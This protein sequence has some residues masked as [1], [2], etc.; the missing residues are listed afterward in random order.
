MYIL[1]IH[2]RNRVNYLSLYVQ[3]CFNIRR[4]L[5]VFMATQRAGG[6]VCPK[7]KSKS[8]IRGNAAGHH[9]PE[10]LNDDYG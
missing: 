5:N 8:K 2:E 10:S 7:Q 3:V 1:Y 9:N 4:A 6:T